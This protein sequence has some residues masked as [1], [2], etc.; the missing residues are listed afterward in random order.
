VVGR[1]LF[2]G[3]GVSIRLSEKQSDY[4]ELVEALFFF[5]WV[6]IGRPKKKQSFDKLRMD[7]AGE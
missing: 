1:P 6:T 2:S 4:A 3:L 5:A 7:G